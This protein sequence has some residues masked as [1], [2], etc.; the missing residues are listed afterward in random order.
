MLTFKHLEFFSFILL[1]ASGYLT[2]VL[3]KV[4]KLIQRK[5]MLGLTAK[6]RVDRVTGTTG[7]FFG[8]I[9]PW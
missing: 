9:R 6:I 8:P 4:N 5:K 2:F 1:Q 7:N 3:V